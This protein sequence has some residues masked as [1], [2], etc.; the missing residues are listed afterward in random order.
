MSST[1]DDD[2][3]VV[4]DSDDS[5]D[6]KEK[7]KKRDQQRGRTPKNNKAKSKSSNSNN[8]KNDNDS[9]S[10]FKVHKG[11]K[12]RDD[13]SENNNSDSENEGKPLA[14]V[15]GPGR[16]KGSTGKKVKKLHTLATGTKIA[17]SYFCKFCSKIYADLPGLKYHL[18]DA[19]NKWK[20]EID[21]LSDAE[22]ESVSE[23][24]KNNK[25]SKR[26]LSTDATTEND[27]EADTNKPLEKKKDGR[28]RKPGSKNKVYEDV[29]METEENDSKVV[30]GWMPT[31]GKENEP[32]VQ[33]VKVEPKLCNDCEEKGLDKCDRLCRK[34]T[35]AN[36]ALKE[37]NLRKQSEIKNSKIISLNFK[38]RICDFETEE[39]SNIFSHHLEEHYIDQIE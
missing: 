20:I 9:D 11:Q 24:A 14:K 39:S 28:G 15:I 36:E 2:D 16:P 21:W 13:S 1:E 3:I 22:D 25:I 31:T 27:T 35:K 30:K 37:M 8:T 32:L 18:G 10:S 4:L 29:P 5:S 7:Q 23:D 38:C 12:K 6:Y 33:K 17:L 26:A 19:H 34:M